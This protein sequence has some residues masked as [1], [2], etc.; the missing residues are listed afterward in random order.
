MFYG[1]VQ[2]LSSVTDQ[3]EVAATAAERIFEV[4]DS[5]PDV[6]DARDA[7]NPT[8]IKGEIVLE[9]VSFS[10]N[11]EKTV[12][13]NINL[14]IEPGQMVGLAGPSGSGK[15]TLAKL[16]SRFYDPD[17]GRILV[18]GNDLR[19]I[20]QRPFRERIG[21]VLQE[22]FLFHGSIAENIGYGR[23]SASREEIIE[24]AKAANAHEFILR[25]PNGY[26]TEVGER[27]TRL[28]GGE[29]Q[30]ISIA[31]AIINKPSIIILDEATSSVDTVTERMIQ[32]ALERLVQGKT[33]IAIAHR[34][35]TL[36][37]ADKLVILE[38]GEIVEEGSHEELL[39][40]E[41]G[42]YANLVKMQTE[43]AKVR[44]V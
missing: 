7:I 44:A 1:P 31:R 40:K 3:V 39:H 20:K 42:V 13:K 11:P 12:L 23:P 26:D 37:N 19:R 9:N 35:S 29:K 27:G 8:D 2:R 34:L 36:R 30:R 22:P 32:E 10:Y 28:S 17:E 6:V 21:V 14:R 5:R 18:D 4:L 41:N 15:T 25:L 33:T 16:I 38:E 24:A 43:M